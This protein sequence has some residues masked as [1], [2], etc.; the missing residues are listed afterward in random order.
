MTDRQH[1]VSSG[2]NPELAAC[3]L[4]KW[5][6]S[7]YPACKGGKKPAVICL[8]GV[9]QQPATGTSKSPT[10]QVYKPQGSLPDAL[11]C[12]PLSPPVLFARRLT[13][14]LFAL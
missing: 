1:A 12:F 9:I 14:T 8:S 11:H 6:Y 10:I 4:E 2:Q 13:V 3:H 5:F 7:C